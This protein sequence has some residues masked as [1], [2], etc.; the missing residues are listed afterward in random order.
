MT[1]A[2][3]VPVV[4]APAENSASKFPDTYVFVFCFIVLAA[5][6]TYIV[7][8][9]A[10]DMV[11]NA[12]GKSIVDP[13]TFH[14]VKQTPVTLLQFITAPFNGMK[15][16]A[17]TI[18]LILLV[19]GF[20]GVINATGTIDATFHTAVAKLHDRAL[21]VIPVI[22]I[23]IAIL[24]ALQIVS[25]AIIAFIAI[26][27]V[28]CKQLKLD[29]LL[30]MSIIFVPNQVGFGATPM[31]A[32]TV[33]IAQ[34]ICDLPL[35]SGFAFRTTFAV[36]ALIVDIAWTM[37]YAKKITKHPEESLIGVYKTDDDEN[38][39][40]DDFTWKHGIILLILFVGFGYYG[41]G[42]I[43]KGWGVDIMSGILLVVAL[44]SA[45]IGRLSPNKTAKS[46][47][48]GAK[49]GLYGA[50]MVGLASA[51]LIMLKDGQIIHTIVR[52]VTIP[53]SYMPK[54]IAAIGMFIVNILVNFIVPSGSGQAYLVMP[55]MA[56]M[57]DVLG[58]SRQVAILAFQ[59]GDG[60]T[61]CI[62]PTGGTTM[63]C[64]AMCGISYPK[65][66]KFFMPMFMLLFLVGCISIT[67]AI[68]MGL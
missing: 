3:N 52:Y 31:G 54:F 57:A 38:L 4:K 8:S 45:I 39:A 35:M 41:W 12:A 29:P 28:L 65:W 11:K 59:Y 55:V 50:M 46:F 16:G 27:I 21:L 60:F 62:I 56:P 5:I 34:Q 63:A 68:A 10:Y 44:L 6:L 15:N 36:I 64:M 40:I 37:W 22:M 25:N 66:M 61:N 48:A 33:V 18:F 49:Q 67:V 26:G 9:G 17:N 20:F 13:A 58:I 24:G 1:T 19:C 53:L 7:P 30:V 32:F 14:F 43:T 23:I 47:V 42:S 51:I 2:N